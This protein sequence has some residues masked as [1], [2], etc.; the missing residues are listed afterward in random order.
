M[1]SCYKSQNCTH[2]RVAQ[3]VPKRSG[4]SAFSQWMSSQDEAC[5]QPLC[6]PEPRKTGHD[7]KFMSFEGLSLFR[8]I[9]CH[10][11][12]AETS[13]DK[14]QIEELESEAEHAR[15]T[16]GAIQVSLQC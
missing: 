1:H 16:I 7:R 11:Q 9:I 12:Q 10:L 4:R 14:Q 15:R 8:V 5:W 2:G 6:V 13:A 3:Q